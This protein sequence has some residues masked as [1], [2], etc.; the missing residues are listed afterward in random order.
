MIPVVRRDNEVSSV[1]DLT[2]AMRHRTAVLA[3][4]TAEARSEYFKAHPYWTELMPLFERW[5]YGKCWYTEAKPRQHGAGFEIDHFRP[6]SIARDPWNNHREWA[7]YPWLAYEW[8]NFR[9]ASPNANKLGTDVD[10]NSAGKGVYFPLRSAVSPVASCEADLEDEYPH[11]LLIDPWVP[12]EVSDISFGEDG[13]VTCTNDNDEF[14][15]HRVMRTVS[16]YNLDHSGLIEKRQ[17]VW[18]ACKKLLDDIDVFARLETLAAPGPLSLKLQQKR[19]E[20]TL[21]FRAD[22]EYAGTARAFARTR[23]EQWV[24]VASQNVPAPPYASFSPVAAR[25]PANDTT[26]A[27]APG[28]ASTSNAPAIQLSFGFMSESVVPT[29]ARPK[30]PRKAVK[31]S[32]TRPRPVA[33]QSSISQVESIDEEVE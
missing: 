13:R 6:K 21:M 29:S 10:G 15:K 24:R 5:S 14:R 33:E 16:V 32:T 7:G 19:Q 22:Q 23:I 3:C 25:A 9:L 20:L 18:R 4:A 26:S 1:W 31:P 30:K 2:E 12:D 28:V 8:T 11:V 17:D 27:G